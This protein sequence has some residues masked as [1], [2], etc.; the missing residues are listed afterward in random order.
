MA[1]YSFIDVRCAMVGPGGSV[2]FGNGS[3]SSEE[4]I[5]ISPNEDIN[6]MAIGADG[7]GQHSLKANKSGTVTVR[8]LKTSPINQVLSLMYNMQT[9][10]S[11]AHGQNTITLALSNG[12]VVTCQQVA[13]KR[14]S[15]LTYAAIAG[16]NEWQF[17]AV[18]IDRTLAA[19]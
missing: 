13:F 19:Y 2:N 4:G 1:V 8:L 3:G 16:M 7:T 12:E 9:A 17:D 10:A 6:D 14:I 5:T 18:K 15:D 11:A